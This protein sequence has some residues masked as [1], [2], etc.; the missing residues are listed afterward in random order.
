MPRL[1]TEQRDQILD[2]LGR[3]EGYPDPDYAAVE[4]NTGVKR[5][6]L[7]SMVRRARARNGTARHDGT[8]GANIASASPDVRVDP[9]QK[10]AAEAIASGATREQ[11]A[12]LAGVSER[13]VYRWQKDPGF[14]AYRADKADEW[15]DGQLEGLRRA[16][17][18][19]LDRLLAE[20]P[21]MSVDQLQRLTVMALDRA[22]V[23]KT[24]RVE[25]KSVSLDLTGSTTEDLARLLEG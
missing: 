20:V 18:E 22:G 3:R 15:R 13:Q 16:A 12:E 21:E 10:T 4:Y 9:R 8:R 11:A 1:T 17:A 2:M 6:T 19:A 14:E 23:P 24:E 5:A 7:R 25:S